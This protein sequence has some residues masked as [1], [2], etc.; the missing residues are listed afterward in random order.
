MAVFSC[1][2]SRNCS[3]CCGG[4]GGG[5]CSGNGSC[6]CSGDVV[7]VVL[8]VAVVIFTGPCTCRCDV[9]TSKLKTLSFHLWRSKSGPNM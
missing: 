2:G 3:Y 8:V 6:S 9:V 5:S 1:S 7:L 4:S